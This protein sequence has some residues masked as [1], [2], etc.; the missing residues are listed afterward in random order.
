[1]YKMSP[2]DRVWLCGECAD[3]MAE[4]AQQETQ[5]IIAAK[6]EE[7]ATSAS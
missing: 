3:E 6:E 2:V 1:M 7:L 4:L 5:A